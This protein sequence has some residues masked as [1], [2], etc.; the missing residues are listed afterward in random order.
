MPLARR[1]DLAMEAHELFRSSAGRA[2]PGVESLTVF[3]RGCRVTSV[4][5]TSGEAARALGKP[6]GR[7]V[8]LDLTPLLRGAED[9]TERAARAV[10]AEL[11]ALMGSGVGSALVAALGNAAMT[12]DAI[13]P[14]AAEHILVTRH[15]C[16]SPAF[17]SL[18]PVSTVAPG[19]LGRTGL[20]ALELVRG[21]V[22]AAQPDA[23]IVIDALA[24][25]S[26][27]RLC[28][29]VQLSDTG[30]VPGS[31]VG[32]HRRALTRETLGLPVFAVGVPTVVDA[33]TLTLDVLAEAG[34]HSVDPAAL[35]GHEGVMVTT[36]DIDAQIRRLARIVGC[37]VDLALQPL[38]FAELCA[39]LD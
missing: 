12:P 8:T 9:S 28:T 22:R 26:R 32:N 35:R 21:A 2:L 1:T 30:I 4:S 14:C 5:V 34:A 6:C 18:S 10:G 27:S 16:G 36:R 15:L 20:E 17:S 31:G 19:V 39:L 38:S 3:R 33:A 13:G 23:L 37:G 29:S 7:Y 25:R 24:S 11:R